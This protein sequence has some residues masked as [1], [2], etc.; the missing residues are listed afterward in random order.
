MLGQ[1]TG[2]FPL[3]ALEAQFPNCTRPVSAHGY[4]LD[5]CKRIGP[6]NKQ[7]LQILP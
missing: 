6:D 1:Q 2:R 3:D 4:A 5:G 7:A